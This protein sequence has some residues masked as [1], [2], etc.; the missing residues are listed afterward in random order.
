MWDVD[1][2][3]ERFKV[4]FLLELPVKQ[5]LADDNKLFEEKLRERLVGEVVAAYKAK[6]DIVG[7]SV[8]RHFEKAVMLQNLDSHWKEHLAA[9]DYFAPRYTFTWFRSEK[10]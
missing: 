7:A 6:E 9:M 3:E 10:S 1:G 5:W 2:L 4:D 8:I